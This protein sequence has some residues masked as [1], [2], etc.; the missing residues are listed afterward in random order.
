MKYIKP[1]VANPYFEDL[2]VENIF[3]DQFMPDAP[4]DFVKVYLYSRYLAEAGE[5]MEPKELGGILGISE[6]GILEAWDHWE[7]VGAIK[8]RYI[9][10]EGRLDFTVEF[11]NLKEQLY[12]EDEEGAEPPRLSSSG[13]DSHPKKVFGNETVKTL[14][15]DIEKKL[16]RTLSVNEL[17]GVISWVDDLGVAPEVI[18]QGIDY[19]QGKGKTSF[20]YIS[21]VIEGWNA[22]GLDTTDKVRSYIE[23]YDQKFVRY[24][25]IMQSLGLSR[26]ATEE[27]RRIIDIWF[28][29]MG[30][31]MDKVLEACST[32]AGISNPNIKYVN[33]VLTN[34]QSDAQKQGRDVNEKPAVTNTVLKEYYDYIREKADREAE[35]RRREIYTKLPQIKE[36]DEKMRDIGIRLAKALLTKG[37]DNVK[38]SEE[39]ERLNEDR[40]ICLV[41][42]NYDVNYTEP[43]YRCSNCNDTGIA[44]MGGPCEACR[45]VR[46]GEAEIWLKEREAA[47]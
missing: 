2:K 11:M 45:E 33:T 32:T 5:A 39:L 36:M 30:Y 26:N 21:A 22:Q 1:K 12:E 4:G 10:G 19:C 13:E 31:N 41:E 28:D 8:K 7:E 27:E 34:W 43:K 44:D 15:G 47:K 20:N 23:E 29:D 16:G 25:R 37:E 35:E 6:A 46:R 3:L 38:L 24:R 14:M 18:L 42:N 17:Q 40:A 9:D